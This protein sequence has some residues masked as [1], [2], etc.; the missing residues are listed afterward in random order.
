MGVPVSLNI[1]IGDRLRPSASG[2]IW[3]L[4]WLVILGHPVTSVFYW[5]FVLE[6][7]ILRTDA[8]SI[9]I[10]IFADLIGAMLVAI[11]MLALTKLA[12]VLKAGPFRL[13]SWNRR[14]PILSALWSVAL[15]VPAI[16]L[17]SLVI[18][19]SVDPKPWYE[20]AWLPHMAALIAWLLVLRGAALSEAVSV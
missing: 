7:G 11:P 9:G 12:L 14:R 19:D 18:G 1:R 20:Y 6:A 15:G 8:D 5:G 10:P 2:L 17:A 13:W 4:A 3:L 16:Y